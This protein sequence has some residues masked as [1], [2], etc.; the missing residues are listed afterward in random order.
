MDQ[1]MDKVLS[2]LRQLWRKENEDMES[3]EKKWKQGL[4]GEKGKQD[5]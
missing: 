2:E 3:E 1:H 4:G 5:I